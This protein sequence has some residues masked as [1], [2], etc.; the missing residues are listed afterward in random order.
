MIPRSLLYKLVKRDPEG[1]LPGLIVAEGS[2]RDMG[3]LLRSRGGEPAYFV[4]M[5][6]PQSQL[7]KFWGNA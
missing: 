5:G 4:A 3:S 1:R 2:K 6:S 7:G